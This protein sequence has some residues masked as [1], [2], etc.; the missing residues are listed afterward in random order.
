MV[1]YPTVIK[2]VN[3]QDISLNSKRQLFSVIL[4][5]LDFHKGNPQMYKKWYGHYKLEHERISK[6]LDDELLKN[7][8]TPFQQENWVSWPKLK[9][10]VTSTRRKNQKNPSEENML[11]AVVAALY[12]S[13][14]YLPPR[15]NIYRTFK[16]YS[17]DQ[18]DPFDVLNN[19]YWNKKFYFNITKSGKQEFELNKQS[20]KITRLIEEYHKLY[21]KSDWLL[22]DPVTKQQLSESSY[23]KIIKEITSSKTHPSG[24]GVRMLRTIFCTEVANKINDSNLR[25]LISFRMGHNISTATKYYDKAYES[26]EHSIQ[27]KKQ[28]MK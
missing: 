19:Y 27:M 9:K 3:E 28:Q 8:K 17:K 4:V 1:D 10:I 14:N 24:I 18:A 23:K 5:L 15:R 7:V 6:I 13:S 22:Q 20:M 16:Y 26:E 2:N 12:L 21:N 25:K 11:R